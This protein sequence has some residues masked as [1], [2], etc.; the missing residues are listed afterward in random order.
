MACCG[1]SAR[2]VIG[3][4]QTGNRPKL[5]KYSGQGS[6]TLFGR[7]TGVRYHF[8]GPGARV[9]VD[10][11]DAPAFEVVKGLEVVKPPATP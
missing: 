10:A 3:Q 8:A 9:L 1:G 2:N 7:I 4:A 11:R 5:F 6:T